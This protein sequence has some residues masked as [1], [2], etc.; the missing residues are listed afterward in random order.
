MPTNQ[1]APHDKEDPRGERLG[2]EARRA[3]VD[4]REAQARSV[5]W[6]ERTR[7]DPAELTRWLRAQHLGEITA[8]ARILALRDRFAA[9]GSEAAR[10]LTIIAGQEDRHGRWVGELLL[11]RGVAPI[12]VAPGP[13]PGEQ[14]Y[15][16]QTLPGVTDLATGA[17]VGAHAERMRLWRLV[18]IAADPQAPADIRAVFGRIVPEERFHERAFRQLASEE[19]LAATAHDHQRGLLVLGLSA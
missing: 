3:A 12:A 18:A 16:A 11:S 9:P 8:S 13:R 10:L 7:D 2:H 15:W 19:A 5:A 4:D 1:T 14:R 17:A 6:W